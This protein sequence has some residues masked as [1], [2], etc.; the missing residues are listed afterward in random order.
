MSRVIVNI[1]SEQTIP[2]YLFIKEFYQP[3]DSLLFIA[4][5]RFSKRIEWIVKTLNLNDVSVESILFPEGGEECW[6]NMESMLKE[7]LSSEQ[8]YIVNLTGGTKYMSLLAQHVFESF[9][10]TFYYIPYP[11]NVILKPLQNDSIPLNYRLTIQE[12]MSNY[13]VTFKEKYLVKSEE[14]ADYIFKRFMDGSMN[15][16]IMD[17]LRRYRNKKKM[18][19]I[20]IETCIPTDKYPRI[21]GLSIFLE[22]IHFQTKDKGILNRAEIEYLTG[23]WFEEYMFYKIQRNIVPQDIKLGVAIQR[24]ENC[25]LN[26][27]DVVFTSGNKLFVIECKTGISGVGMFNQTVYKASAIKEAVLGLS[28][29]TIIASLAPEDKDLKITARNM[30]VQYKC[31][32]DIEDPSRFENFIN[33]I[34]EIAKN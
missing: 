16:S 7:R 21:E 17:L 13:N 28:A 34:K 26:D 4:S 3:E 32:E 6:N 8:C 15:Y 14:Y 12:Y 5:Q 30:G 25:N 20:S 27:L 29:N 19:I 1:M 9:N 2:N 11:K 10:S 24:T 33:Q 22:E 23:G 18:A 31:R